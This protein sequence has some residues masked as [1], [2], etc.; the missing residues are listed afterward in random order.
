MSKPEEIVDRLLTL[1]KG[2]RD[3]AIREIE[4]LLIESKIEEIRKNMYL[5]YFIPEM[6]AYADSRIIELQQSPKDKE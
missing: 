2:S 5:G 4:E 1:E 3:R 6:E